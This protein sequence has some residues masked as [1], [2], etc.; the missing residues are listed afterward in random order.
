ME[1]K[2]GWCVLALRFQVIVTVHLLCVACAALL[3]LS[4]YLIDWLEKHFGISPTARKLKD[5]ESSQLKTSPHNAL[6][7]PLENME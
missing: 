2:L 3:I 7:K 6:T 5:A 1:E 4:V